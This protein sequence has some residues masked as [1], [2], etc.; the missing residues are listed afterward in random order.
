MKKDHKKGCEKVATIFIFPTFPTTLLSTDLSSSSHFFHKFFR[1]AVKIDLCHF[2][3]GKHIHHA[4]ETILFL[5]GG[6]VARRRG[7]GGC[8]EWGLGK[9]VRTRKYFYCCW[10]G[11]SAQNC[12]N[13]RQHDLS[14]A[15]LRT[16]IERL[17]CR[18]KGKVPWLLLCL[19][20]V[21]VDVLQ[22]RHNGSFFLTLKDL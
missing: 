10:S 19:H 7:G 18:E 4:F 12:F 5:G 6:R 1:N 2:L 3:G 9:P 16:G 20:Q 11:P 13:T 22:P 15:V 21:A 17:P 8:V 14:S